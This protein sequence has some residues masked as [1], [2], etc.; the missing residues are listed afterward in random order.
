LYLGGGTPSQLG[1]DGIAGLARVVHAR[2]DF[3][4]FTIEANP[5]DVT[6][7]ALRAWRAAGVTRLSL[8]VQSFDPA[9]L[10]WMHRTHDADAAGVAV[11]AARAAGIAS[12]SVD[13]I[14]ALPA[15]LNRDFADDLAR[16]L[17][18]EPD[19][20]SLYGLTVEPATPLGK[21]VAHGE[22]QPVSDNRY[23]D[24]YALA[25]ERLGGHGFRFYEVSN[26]A[27][28]GHE[29]IH[30]AAYWTRAPYLGLGPAAHSFDGAARWWNA[31][32]YATWLRHLAVPE[33]PVAG[34]EVPD[35]AARRLEHL[36]LGLRTARGVQLPPEDHD[37][38]AAVRRWQQAGWAE[39][40]DT[41]AGGMTVRLT[42][43]GWLRL[44]ELVASL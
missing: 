3:E 23:A 10:A 29:A 35:D 7:E 40:S 34:R 13:L 22:I 18:L 9:V 14:F 19:H 6:P 38:L 2:G 30:N 25:H 21:Q 1:G 36:Y 15:A 11:R 37:T 27:R 12:V 28:P 5:D 42:M 26:A 44:D 24:E 32:A 39:L 41:G 31:P 4:E 20:V 8:G 16:A 43:S 17:A 33:S